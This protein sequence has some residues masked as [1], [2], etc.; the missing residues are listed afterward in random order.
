VAG[1][2]FNAGSPAYTMTGNTFNLTAGITN[3]SSNLQT[4]SNTGGLTQSVSVTDTV[5]A[6]G[7]ITIT[8]GLTETGSSGL[9]L[10][11]NGAGGL[12]TL[13]SLT[14][15]SGATAAVTDTIA[16]TGNV[17]INGA[18]ANGS[19]FANGLSYTGTGTLSLG[20]NNTYTGLTSVSS[21]VLI[22]SG[23]NTSAVGGTT[24]SSTGT[25]VVNSATAIGATGTLTLGGGTINNTSG[26]A[27]TESNN[28]PIAVSG[29]FAAFV[30][31]ETSTSN[32]NLGTGAVANS[33]NATITFAGNGT[34]LTLGGVM[35]NTTGGN[36]T[37]SVNGAGD[38]LVLGGYAL[39]NSSTS[40]SDTINGSA[41]VNI[42]GAVTNGSTATAGAL[43]I[44]STGTVTLGGNNTYGGLTT[45]SNGVFVLTGNNSSATGGVTVSS[46]TLDV[47]SAGALGATGTVTINGGVIDN[48][49]GSPVTESN[50]P[51]ITLGGNFTYGGSNSLNLG[52]GTVALSGGRT[53]TL[54]TGNNTTLTFGGAAGNSTTSAITTTIN[55]GTGTGESV[56][57]GN[58]FALEASSGTG[59][60][61]D[62]FNGSGAV[63]INGGISN[64][65]GSGA[66]GLTY[67]GTGTLTI[68]NAG[69]YSGTTTISSGAIALGDNAALGTSL[70]TASGGTLTATTALS[71]VAN[72]INDTGTPTIGGS[73][74]LTFS[75]VFTN[76][77]GNRT[78]TVNNTGLTSL[79]GGNV[80]L[81]EA[82]GSGRTLTIN[83][84]GSLTIGDV[85]ANY[86]GS[87]SA[88]GLTYSG[89]GTL[90]LTAANTY[91]GA[92]TINSG[93]VVLSGSGQIN[94]SAITLSGGSLSTGASDTNAITGGS[95]LSVGGAT[96]NL[97]ESNNYTGTT[98][99]GNTGTLG[100]VNA[101]EITGGTPLGT[102]A[103]GMSYGTLNIAPGAGASGA[104]VDTV[105]SGAEQLTYYNT[106]TGNGNVQYG[107]VNTIVLNKGTASSL[108]LALNST[109]NTVFNRSN[110]GFLVINTNSAD[111]N[112]GENITFGVAQTGNIANGMFNANIVGL[113]TS[114][115]GMGDFLTAGGTGTTQLVVSTYNN[116]V[117]S[118]ATTANE[119]A[120]VTGNV[121]IT[122]EANTIRG[123]LVQNGDTLT[124]P[125]S[126]TGSLT[127]NGGGSGIILNGGNITGGTILQGNNNELDIWDFNG[128]ST[129]SS[130]IDMNTGGNGTNLYFNG[131]QNLTVSGAINQA[132]AN[133]IITVES[134][135]LTLTGSLGQQR[136]LTVN[137]G[138]LN[139]NAPNLAQ[140]YTLTVSVSNN[141]NS[142]LTESYANDLTGTAGLTVTGGTVTLSQ[143]NNYTGSTTLTAGV[144][145]V[146]G[147]GG[148][149]GSAVSTGSNASGTISLSAVNAMTG[150]SSLSIAGN[151]NGGTGGIVNIT[152]SQNYTGGTT[153]G[154]GGYNGGVL[155]I[156]GSG[157]IGGNI[158]ELAGT[159]NLQT[160]GAISSGTFTYKAGTFTETAA[161]AISGSAALTVYGNTALTLNLANNYT[162]ATTI[163]DAS[164]PYNLPSTDASGYNGNSL[165]GVT[166]DF[167]SASSP[168]N[169][170]ISPSSA[171][172]LGEG[173]LNI[174]GKNATAN[175]QTFN[176]TTLDSG[177]V[178]LLVGNGNS[179]GTMTVNLGAL[180]RTT[181]LINFIAGANA[182]G[183]SSTGI[184]NT[185]TANANFAG[186]QQTILGGWALFGNSWAVSGS[187]ATAGVITALPN[188]SYTA[189]STTSS[190]AGKDI[191]AGNQVLGI[192]SAVSTINSLRFG[193][194]GS[195]D[196]AYSNADSMG[197]G[198]AT[199]TITIATGGILVSNG[200]VN[201]I[202]GTT[203]NDGG[204]GAGYGGY[205]TSGN[206]QD[207]IVNMTSGSLQLA[208][209]VVNNGATPIGLTVD[210]GEQGN[211]GTLSLWGNNTFTGPFVINGGTVVLDSTN[212]LSGS[213]GGVPLVMNMYGVG[214]GFLNLNGYNATLT[215]I[216][217][218]I[219]TVPSN[220]GPSIF[221]GSGTSGTL[222]INDA[223]NDTY[224]GGISL[225]GGTGTL[226]FVKSGSG[227]LTLSGNAFGGNSAQ[228]VNANYVGT[229]TVNS[230]K[231]YIASTNM[232]LS[233][234]S[235]ITVNSGGSIGATTGVTF[236]YTGNNAVTG[237]PFGGVFINGG[238]ALDLTNG[239]AGEQ[240]KITGTASTTMLT[241]G[242]G[243]GSAANLDLD[244]GATADNVALQNTSFLSVGSTG[245]Q[246]NLVGLGGLT[247]STQN[248][249]TTGGFGSGSAISTFVGNYGASGSG[250]AITLG[251]TSGNFGGYTLALTNSGSNTLQLSETANAFGTNV[252]ANGNAV[253][254]SGNSSVG[255]TLS[256]ATSAWNSFTGGNANNSNFTAT[257]TTGADVHQSPNSTIN[258]H[259]GAAPSNS[260]ALANYLN[261][262]LGANYTIN[263]LTYDSAVGSNAIS[264]SGDY[265]LT[266][267]A[268]TS[269][270]NAAGNGITDSA[271][272]GTQ[273]LATTVVAL[274]ANQTWTVTNAADTLAVS[275]GVSDNGGDF[276]LTKAGSGTLTLSGA[277]L[278]IGTTT[279][280]AGTLEF[281]KENSLYA[282]QTSRWTAA[283]ITVNSGATMAFAVGGT[284]D[285]VSSDLD[286]VLALGTATTG[287]LSGSFAGIDTTDGNFSYGSAIANPNS[288][289][290]VLGL[291][292]LG[293]NTLTL[294]GS[295]TFTG[296]VTIDGGT[297]SVGTV[298]TTS[299]AQPLGEGTTLTLAGASSASPA[300]FV[301]TGG[302]STLYQNVTVSTGDYGT[303]SNTGGGVLTLAGTLSKNGSVLNLSGGKLVVTGTITGALANSDLNVNNASTVGL[304]SANTYNGPTT[305][306]GNSAV[307][308]G[309]N[310]A[311]PTGTPT[312]LTLGVSGDSGTN[313]LDLAGTNQTVASLAVASGSG[314]TNEVVSSNGSASTPQVGSGTSSTTG[315]LTV[316]VASGNDTYTGMLGAGSANNLA[317]VKANSGT[318]TLTGSNIYTGGTTVSAGTLVVSN[319]VAGGSATGTGTTTV[320]AGGTLAGYGMSS[321]TGFSISGTGTA[322][323]ARA[324]VLAGLNSASDTNTS[325]VL[326]L[327][328]SA[329]GTIANANLTFNI[330]DQ[331]AG[332]LG[333]SPANSGTEL[334]V[335]STPITFGLGVQSTT[336]TLNVQNYGIIA[337]NTPYVLIAG[338]TTGGV[339]QYSNLSL[340]TA[341]GSLAT[342]LI[343]PILN[344]N[345]GGT[346]NLTLSMSGLA[347]GYYGG[348]SYLFLY[349][350]STTGADDIEVEV[351]PEPG[352]WAMM[353]GGLAMLVFWQRARRDQK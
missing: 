329:A 176:G 57:F 188:S 89:S 113:G 24:V 150:A 5:T 166:F 204:T 2:T 73:N 333:T 202:E 193:T 103:I 199:S 165:T 141:P 290:N 153:V 142:N 70:L 241:L 107:G 256:G 223:A 325:Q 83:G 51:P 229:T 252:T 349:Q 198:A 95:T 137:G 164:N 82:S 161:N 254:Y 127:F 120:N 321:G 282:D 294:S 81:S 42:T 276:G 6:A 209:N 26:G 336:L 231:L 4:F 277:D 258:L 323:G 128:P 105:L 310:G 243:S 35:T 23:N 283:N 28:S 301:Y 334:A 178:N 240:L 146:T 186:G 340:G 68:G 217:D 245:V 84:T 212:A 74:N 347:A 91:T 77:G 140:T 115:A 61:V 300:G 296:G 170:I 214:A 230:G 169:N 319:T 346:G 267:N 268:G 197:Q 1:I 3:N 173:G 112:S 308:T 318:L 304:T 307:I 157:S 16:G 309:I 104:V 302:S 345:F 227:T 312:A 339:D 238:G 9:G 242:S 59:A 263:S 133:A 123:L 332:G 195:G 225:D 109:S 327:K 56:V 273:T 80:Y 48:T 207:L 322:T 102:G 85:I 246:I 255:G 132:N 326:T 163:F 303:I 181:G 271:T 22:L 32:L 314:A 203:T 200:S 331:V 353:L 50:A 159:I 324:T 232:N 156:S 228:N 136:G 167:S 350:N 160:A 114:V 76:S 12:L 335:G 285:F 106:N 269:G 90:T 257:S 75:G 248:I 49:S 66:N 62:T 237:A 244:V 275:A 280:S 265:V 88:G 29:S 175:S 215:D 162:G 71:G 111:L 236:G 306:S 7:G 119:I 184:I 117:A 47:N 86:N 15:N 192:N 14:L 33:A 281:L 259:F 220:A 196:V 134:G 291:I 262:T 118:F 174:I 144:I 224:D 37:T 72:T 342:G 40:R 67:S 253:Y 60:I 187:G 44:N 139:L 78:L 250:K 251:T 122:S 320:S 148:I 266:I 30:A 222:T 261:N 299:T 216:S 218:N 96:A 264:T 64:G 270:G 87:G 46:G 179:G 43:T 121:S 154:F 98:I 352:T 138:T 58:G 108:T 208:A 79:T 55:N 149:N 31:G 189:Y 330:N 289:T 100:L 8:N 343:T 234:T 286:T 295:S 247:G 233:G 180:T 69:S 41:N 316:S 20:G 39:S 226:S 274:G 34:T 27:L 13:G 135:T 19:A 185:T 348:N 183:G 11:V 155:N 110:S 45:L 18:V 131:N 172:V 158:N 116:H 315:T 97:A 17:T 344:S 210:G 292:K 25:L 93:A 63:T 260:T 38:T 129:I 235:L 317:L 338:L 10:T 287:F 191:E 194:A 337:A 130:N 36:Q 125:A 145:N 328:G 313:I 206:G 65:S 168:T 99:I 293:P 239:I 211:T 272:S 53:I 151:P 221:T 152:Q 177:Y 101:T 190:N 171:L 21:G 182:N 279:T 297:V 143:A 341:T 351:V 219:G 278:Y 205:I 126:S 311:L 284:G 201:Y 147:S 124:L 92:T 305:I 52:T 94:G 288:G 249:L 54:G 213:G 298:A